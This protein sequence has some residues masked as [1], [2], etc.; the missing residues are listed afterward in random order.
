MASDSQ[1]D[2]SSTL[3]LPAGLKA[4]QDRKEYEPQCCWCDVSSSVPNVPPPPGLEQHGKLIEL[5]SGGN[6]EG[7][8]ASA[9]WK[10]WRE[11]RRLKL[12]TNVFVCDRKNGRILLG[13]KKRGFGKNMYNGFGGKVEPNESPMEAAVR[14]LKE[15]AG[16]SANLEECGVL[17]FVNASTEYCHYVHM[18][19]AYEYEGEPVETEEMHPHW[20]AIPK[21]YRDAKPAFKESS[22]SSSASSLTFPFSESE[23]LPPI[24]LEQMWPDDELWMP[25]LLRGQYFVGRVDFGIKDSD[26]QHGSW[27][28]ERWWF[29]V[30]A[31]SRVLDCLKLIA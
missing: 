22:S 7:D 3:A 25:L 5:F 6:G 18:Y 12:F 27:T 17:L 30:E 13:M 9:D 31:S 4:A 19:R 16:I 15:E 29:E 8:D 14:E 11:L 1:R 26:A 28:M 21:E 23:S 20:F 24:P 2:Q 10:S